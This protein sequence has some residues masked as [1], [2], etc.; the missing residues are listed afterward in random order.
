[1]GFR[2][3]HQSP[4]KHLA[5][6]KRKTIIHDGKRDPCSPPALSTYEEDPVPSGQAFP[7]SEQCIRHVSSSSKVRMLNEGALS[8]SYPGLISPATSSQ[9][10]PTGH[11]APQL[12][13]VLHGSPVLFWA[14]SDLIPLPLLLSEGAWFLQD[15]NA[16]WHPISLSL[17]FV[18]TSLL[19]PPHAST[20]R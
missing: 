15:S 2:A 8:S 9:P 3:G 1:M 18:P 17:P 10:S 20:L 6:T 4:L 13:P 19:Q 7:R 5:L 12:E 14:Y 16:M 11:R